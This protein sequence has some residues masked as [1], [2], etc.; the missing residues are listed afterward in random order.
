MTPQERKDYILNQEK[1]IKMYMITPV[2]K[3]FLQ[4]LKGHLHAIKR[5]LFT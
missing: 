4:R 5:T 1:Y 3:T 2:K